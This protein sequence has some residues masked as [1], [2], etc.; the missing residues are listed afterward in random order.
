MFPEVG[1]QVTIDRKHNVSG[2][3]F[4]SLPRDLQFDHRNYIARKLIKKFWFRF[5]QMSELEAT[6]FFYF[7]S[8]SLRAMLHTKKMRMNVI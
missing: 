4:P 6:K 1:K 3:M 5:V 2:T 8:E 7:V